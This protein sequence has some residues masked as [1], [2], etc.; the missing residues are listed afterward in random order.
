M[1]TDRAYQVSVFGSGGFGDEL[2]EEEAR[3]VVRMPREWYREDGSFAPEALKSGDTYVL[4][5]LKPGT[6]SLA[7]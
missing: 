7:R 2:A 1:V 4:V 5:E 6:Y 3:V